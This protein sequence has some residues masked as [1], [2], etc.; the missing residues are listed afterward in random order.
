MT[1]DE[2]MR[3]VKEDSAAWETVKTK[4]RRKKNNGKE[5]DKPSSASEQSDYG[6]PPVT[7]PTVPG[8][9]WDMTVVHVDENNNV[10]E[11]EME[12]QDSEWE[13]A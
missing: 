10:V 7:A 6:V 2:Q 11:R 4:E 1:E 3:K 5:N 13:V 12:V 8:K 9:K